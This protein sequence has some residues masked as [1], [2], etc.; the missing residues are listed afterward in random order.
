MQCY[1]SISLHL[2]DWVKETDSAGQVLYR[3]GKSG[4]VLHA[5]PQDIHETLLAGAAARSLVERV[6]H[7]VSHRAHRETA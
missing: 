1:H 5:R 2:P 3:H 6:H 7:V 4:D